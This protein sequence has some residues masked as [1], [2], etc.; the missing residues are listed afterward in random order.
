[1]TQRAGAEI[2]RPGYLW[3]PAVGWPGPQIPP[4]VNKAAGRAGTGCRQPSS[5]PC[6]PPFHDS[7]TT[8]GREIMGYTGMTVG[9][10][11]TGEVFG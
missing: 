10:E 8:A 1:M 5:C 6:L 2:G 4:A 11:V 9:L 3:V 7:N